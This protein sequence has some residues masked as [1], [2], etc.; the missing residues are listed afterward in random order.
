MKK[1]W[2]IQMELEDVLRTS[3][4]YQTIMLIVG[5]CMGTWLGWSVHP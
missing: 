3:K 1:R 4:K 2:E 5:I